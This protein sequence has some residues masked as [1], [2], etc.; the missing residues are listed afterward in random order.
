[1]NTIPISLYSVKTQE[2]FDMAVY[3]V[4]CKKKLGFWEDPGVYLE[5]ETVMC[6]EC[7]QPI[8]KYFTLLNESNNADKTKILEKELI[9]VCNE[10]YS[11]DLATQVVKR[12]HKSRV[13]QNLLTQEEKDTIR[14]RH[15]DFKDKVI[16]LPLTTTHNFEGYRII[17]YIDVVV[18]E[19]VFKN[20]FWKSLDANL[21][22]FGNSF[23]FKQTEMSGAN[24][25]IANAREYAVQKFKQKAVKL[26]A[27][28][29]VGVEFESSFGSDVVRV[30]VFG[31]AVVI[32]KLDD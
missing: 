5:D 24:A 19:I 21:E 3:C 6:E 25:L 10:A 12:F 15:E 8:R 18:E 26:G 2:E 23:T 20:G 28:A 27:N 30:A 13:N 1:M 29:V 14:Q 32:Q 17:K 11:S 16:A 7:A 4:K 22:D 9:Q 31:T